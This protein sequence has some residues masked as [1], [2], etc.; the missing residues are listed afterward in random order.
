MVSESFVMSPV[1]LVCIRGDKPFFVFV[2]NR[3]LLFGLPTHQPHTLL[4][5]FKLLCPAEHILLLL[6]TTKQQQEHQSVT[7]VLY[8]H[9]YSCL[10]D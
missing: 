1:I 8:E 9:L 3:Y 6:L 10:C 4:F 2:R 5:S 7:F